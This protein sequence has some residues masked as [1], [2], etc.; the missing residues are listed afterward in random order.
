MKYWSYLLSICIASS[1][2]GN[3]VETDRS[4]QSSLELSITQSNLSLV[5]ENRS[6]KL[7]Q[8]EGR[9][10]VKDIPSSILPE[11]TLV[12]SVT[13]RVSFVIRE[14]GFLLREVN[15]ADLLKHF[16]GKEIQLIEKSEEGKT[17]AFTAKLLSARD[18]GIYQ[19]GSEV[20]IGHPGMKVLPYLPKGFSSE[21]QLCW[22]YSNQ[23]RY[24]QFIRIL[25]LTRGLSWSANYSI[26][27]EPNETDASFAAWVNI[28]NYAGVDFHKA[29]VHLLAGEVA[30]VEPRQEKVAMRALAMDMN[31]M[32]SAAVG[33]THRYLLPNSIDLEDQ[34]E[35]QYP[36]FYQSKLEVNKELRVQGL[37][38]YYRG[39]N[40]G[41]MPVDVWYYLNL[42]NTEENFLGK[43][44]PS[45][46]VRVYQE[47]ANGEVHFIGQD[48]VAHSPS[49]ETIEVR[50]SKVFD[51]VAEKKQTN[52]RGVS[53]DV[54]QSEWLYQL[55]NRKDETVTV[56]VIE[57]MPQ[58]WRMVNSSH[59][60]DKIAANLV[61]FVVELKAGETYDIRYEIET[62][63]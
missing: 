22:A 24:Q 31:T 8:G 20:S 5:K 17:E 6:F 59:R 56:S 61:K 57:P 16:V 25:Y 58:N 11:S 43:P 53:K 26:T 28:R 30:S 46:I 9:L 60:W 21:A 55:R 7:P 4:H 29:K 38:S 12:E 34:S 13:D 23:N 44:F 27:L 37:P 54:H 14:Q 52:Y 35:K 2:V 45:G 15:S 48:Q 3:E 42:E 63:F 47:Q 32:E 62:S 10:L 39:R 49:G 33:E 36:F 40:E 51:I 50:V 1:L 19:I 18:G 41:T